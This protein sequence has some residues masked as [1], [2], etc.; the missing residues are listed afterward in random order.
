MKAV[1]AVPEE[2]TPV[3]V[4]ITFET[5]EEI[6]LI[7]NTYAVTE[8]LA[9]E[10]SVSSDCQKAVNNLLGNLSSVICDSVSPL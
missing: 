4:T 9:L 8:L 5:Q 6:D 2:F 10:G 3:S 1:R 7:Y